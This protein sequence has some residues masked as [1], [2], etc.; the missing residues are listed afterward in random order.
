MMD[1]HICGTNAPLWEKATILKKY[2][3]SYYRCPHCGFVQT[4]KP[5]WLEEAYSETIDAEDIGLL[6]RNLDNAAVVSR[7]VQVFFPRT[8]T[9]LDVGGGYGVFVRLMRDRGFDFQWDDKYTRNLFARG[10]EKNRERYDIVTAF[11]L[12][13]HYD[14][15]MKEVQALAALGDVI[16]FSTLLLPEP[17]PKPDEWWYYSTSTGQHISFYTKRSLEHCAQA[18]GRYYTGSTGIH[19]F[20]K[21]PISSWQFWLAV[22]RIGWIL[23]RAQRES[24]L[25]KDYARLTGEK[26]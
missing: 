2:E 26:I 1:C 5:Y 14:E 13:E 11:E 4:E 12:F 19:V 9:F 15:P 16:I 24:L 8:E 18:I 23:G 17:A 20:S 7:L 3:V 6:R 10:F 21:R 25:P 22:S